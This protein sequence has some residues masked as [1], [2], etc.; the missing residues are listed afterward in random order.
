MGSGC[1]VTVTSHM[2]HIVTAFAT[3]AHTVA[4]A[5]TTVVLQCNY[6]LGGLGTKCRTVDRLGTL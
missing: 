1:V 5:F 6:Y 3:T 4:A 2:S